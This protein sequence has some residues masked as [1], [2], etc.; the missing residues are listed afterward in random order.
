MVK[1]LVPVIAL[2]LVACDTTVSDHDI[3]SPATAESPAQLASLRLGAIGQFAVAYGG[4][5]DLSGGGHEGEINMT[6]LMTDEYVDLDT[7]QTRVDVDLRQA[8]DNNAQLDAL[9][10]DVAKARVATEKSASLYQQYLP[11]DA[12]YSES[13]SLAGYTYALFGEIY[14]SGVP[15]SSISDGGSISYGQPLTTDSIYARALARFAGALAA[16][17]DSTTKNLAR[18]GTAR[19]LLDMGRYSD[20]AAAVAAVPD[21]FVYVIEYSTNTQRQNNGVWYFGPENGYFSMFDREGGNGLPFVSAH[22][23]R[24]TFDSTGAPG[25]SLQPNTDLISELKY[26]TAASDINLADGVEARLILA[27]A[28][29]HGAVAGDYA[30][31]LNNL[32]SEFQPSLAPLVEPADDSAQVDQVFSERAFWLFLTAHRMGDLRRLIGQY[33]RGPETVF[34]TGVSPVA[35]LPYGTDVTFPVSGYAANNPNF[36]GCVSV[37]ARRVRDDRQR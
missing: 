20:A 9:F 15:F 23:P 7:Y 19:V 18:V 3:V 2:G 34:P 1:R 8:S 28:Q 37:A 16:A 32:R 5:G 14:C 21:S 11:H 24:V 30:T 13:L 12:G 29:Q 22:D 31:T 33:G 35:G 6:A 10:A 27:E 4:A 26:P 36:H 25:Y 17:P